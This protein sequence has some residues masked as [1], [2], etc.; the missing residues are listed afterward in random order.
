MTNNMK[1]GSSKQTGKQMWRICQKHKKRWNNL[2]C[3]KR[4]KEEAGKLG[5]VS[6]AL[7]GPLLIGILHTLLDRSQDVILMIFFE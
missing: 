3:I 5:V 7:L 1:E 6:A 4:E 2:G